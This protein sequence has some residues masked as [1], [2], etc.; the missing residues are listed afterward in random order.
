M[1]PNNPFQ[2][3]FVERKH[4]FGRRCCEIGK[5]YIFALHLNL[6]R[7]PLFHLIKLEI[8]GQT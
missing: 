3:L 4:L 5:F 2:K 7:L 8:T 1:L 6:A